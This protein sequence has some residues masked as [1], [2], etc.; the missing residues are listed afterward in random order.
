VHFV[1]YLN[2]FAIHNCYSNTTVAVFHIPHSSCNVMTKKFTYGWSCLHVWQA[3]L[4]N[5]MRIY[6]LNQSSDIIYIL[7]ILCNSFRSVVKLGIHRPVS[8]TCWILFYIN[9]LAP[10][11]IYMCVCVCVCVCLWC[12]LWCQKNWILCI[13]IW[14]YLALIQPRFK[15]RLCADLYRHLILVQ[16]G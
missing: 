4:Y 13:Y 1:S 3:S 5:I 16:N 14:F 7:N 9:H 12:T 10:N 2:T 8:I 6:N 11:V 15:F